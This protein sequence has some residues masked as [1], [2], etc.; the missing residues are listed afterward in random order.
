VIWRT[1]G[2]GKPIRNEHLNDKKRNTTKIYSG[3]PEDFGIRGH[4]ELV[5]EHVEEDRGAEAV[6]AAAGGERTEYLRF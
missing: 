3:A 2:E 5:G 4:V 1:Y 6:V